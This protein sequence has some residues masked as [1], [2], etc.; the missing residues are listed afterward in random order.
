MVYRQHSLHRAFT[1]DNNKITQFDKVSRI[2]QDA[3]DD[4]DNCNDG[5]P[6]WN[7]GTGYTQP[8]Q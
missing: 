8:R 2:L 4:T 6:D 5:S 7:F 3:V 1:D